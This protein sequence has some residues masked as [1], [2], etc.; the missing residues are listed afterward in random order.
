MTSAELTANQGV[1]AERVG[2][3]LVALFAFDVQWTE[4]LTRQLVALMSRAALAR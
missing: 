4:A 1:V 3:A 2:D